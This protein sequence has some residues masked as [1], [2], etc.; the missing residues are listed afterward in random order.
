VVTLA[1]EEAMA[2]QVKPGLSKRARILIA[3]VVVTVSLLVLTLAIDAGLLGPG[4]L[5]APGPDSLP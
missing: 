3:L 2:T 5:L 1:E 4:R